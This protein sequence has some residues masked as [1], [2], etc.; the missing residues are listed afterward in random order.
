[1]FHSP[2]KSPYE[3]AIMSQIGGSA[4]PEAAIDQPARPAPPFDAGRVLDIA[5]AVIAIIFIAPLLLALAVLIWSHDGGGPLFSQERIG[6][7]GRRFRCFKFRSMVIDAEAR[8][9]AL[10]DSDPAAREE[11]LADHKLREDPRITAL[12]RFLRR[13]SLD[14]LPQLFNILRGDMSVVGPRPIVQAEV[15]RYGRF[16]SRYCSVRPGLTGLWQ[17]NGR[18]DVSYRERV[19]YDVLYARRRSLSANVVIIV[20]TVPAVLQR[21]GCY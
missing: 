16:F 5:V 20:M 9:A 17:I 7:G 11:W 4:I 19:A 1:M 6:Y 14:E 18:N 3:A 15:A 2:S 10:L 12:G 21:R 8:L 13:S